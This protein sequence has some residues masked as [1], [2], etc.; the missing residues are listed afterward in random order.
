MHGFTLEQLE[1]LK[2]ILDEDQVNL[3]IKK[4]MVRVF[5]KKINEKLK[6]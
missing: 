1:E 5:I 3:D 6:S 2:V 4:A